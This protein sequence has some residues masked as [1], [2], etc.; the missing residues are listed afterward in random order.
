M[1]SDDVVYDGGHAMLSRE[2][3]SQVQQPI[4]TYKYLTADSLQW[5][6]D[7]LVFSVVLVFYCAI[8]RSAIFLVVR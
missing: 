1:L 2:A 7:M 4:L 3:N 8:N 6:T 5:I